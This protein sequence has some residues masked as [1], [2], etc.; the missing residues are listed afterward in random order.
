MHSRITDSFEATLTEAGIMTL[1]PEQDP[2]INLIPYGTFALADNI[3]LC[4]QLCTTVAERTKAFWTL[5]EFKRLQNTPP[6][7]PVEPKL[8]DPQWWPAPGDPLPPNLVARHG[9]KRARQRVALFNFTQAKIAY[10]EN[11][12]ACLDRAQQI[13]SIRARLD[14]GEAGYVSYVLE[15][16]RADFP[17]FAQE[18]FLT[19]KPLWISEAARERH[20]FICAGT[21]SGKS[22]SLLHIIRHYITKNTA[23]ALVVLDPHY[24][25]AE[26]VARFRELA[27][28]DR[29]VLISPGRFDDCRVAFN[30]FDH[31]AKDAKSLNLA[32]LQFRGALEQIIGDEFSKA[33]RP[34]LTPCL[35]VLLHKDGTTFR[36]L[37][38]FMD[39][40]EN[41]DLVRYGLTDL[42]NP[43]DRAFFRNQFH[44]ENFNSTK[45]TL[46]YR[47]NDIIRDP[48][49]SAFLCNESTFDL[50][51]C[52]RQRKVI[53][54]QFNPDG[55]DSQAIR[56]IGQLIT[57]NLISFAM[58]RPKPKRFPIHL[59][60][61]ECQ[62]FVSPM[63]S[64]IMGETRKFGL[65]ATLATQRTTQV[66]EESPG[67]LDAI[68]G[69]VGCYIIGRNKGKTARKMADEQPITKDDIQ[70]LPG[71][72]FFQIETDRDPVRTRID[73][74][75]DMHALSEAAWDKELQK[76]RATYYHQSAPAENHDPDTGQAGGSEASRLTSVPRTRR[77]PAAPAPTHLR[78]KPTG[79]DA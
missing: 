54:F 20:T 60:A 11:L 52:L 36:D 9:P 72:T 14:F 53:V 43:D 55:M 21:G 77:K 31:P 56:T 79:S 70:S 47:F 57:A 19:P 13:R 49:V 51:K 38:R 17:A 65:H 35:G 59:F 18:F 33:Q 32:Q 27:E 16:L 8:D 29:L 67:V 78:K 3:A 4:A 74:I 48:S 73:V 10:E 5:T 71:M 41:A 40:R 34:L 45:Q 2:A 69:N 44:S 64:K 30:P 62:Y 12:K 75:G 66:E 61:D 23:P 24:D 28:Q 76:Q 50:A 1:P 58:R 42:P 46:R 26:D 15:R 68:L 7:K 6:E 37:V 63:I 22:Q 25:L 39:D